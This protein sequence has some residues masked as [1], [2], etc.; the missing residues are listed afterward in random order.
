MR[1]KVLLLLLIIILSV[2]IVVR[3]RLLNI[4]I[5]R[6]EAEYAYGGQLIL[7][8]QI[9]YLEQYSLK[10]PGMFI[11]Y[12]IFLFV[13]G[14]SSIGIHIGLLIT[15][16]LSCFLIFNISK[17][18]FNNCSAVIVTS[19]FAILSLNENIQGFSANAE[20]F[21][22]LFTL[23]G[24]FYYFKYSE[25][26]LRKHLFLCGLMMAISF[27]MKQ[28]GFAFI[29]LGF[30]LVLHKQISRKEPIIKALTNIL[31]Y[32]FGVLLFIIFT[33]SLMYFLGT[34]EKF[35]FLTF[36][37][38]REYVSYINLEQGISN[39]VKNISNVIKGDY[40]LWIISVFGLLSLIWS[41][42]NRKQMFFIITLLLTSL[43]A[44][45]PG[46]Y[47]RPHYFILLLPI[48]AIMAGLFFNS[49]FNYKLESSK[50]IFSIIFPI[51]L[52]I[53]VISFFVFSHSA[54]LFKLS[55]TQVSKMIFGS[56]PFSESPEIAKYIVENSIEND[57]VAIIGAEPQ[58][59]FYCKRKSAT[60]Y[61]YVYPFLENNHYAEQMTHE[62]FREIE[63]S[64]PKLIVFSNHSGTWFGDE[65]RKK[66]IIEWFN[67]FVNNKYYKSGIIDILN[68]STTNYYWDN[69]INNYT[70]KGD[71]WLTVY[72]KLK[73]N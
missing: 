64:A 55:P 42:T 37:Y 41:K 1:F 30:V 9:P 23:A 2:V 7:N 26:L 25:T 31:L 38:A 50:K 19:F 36:T 17:K 63:K 47:F 4:P 73:N 3:I 56:N 34:F 40:L 65:T 49:F 53:T 39:F 60:G 59:L 8:G 18:L 58:M 32:I 27:T 43:L 33:L 72:K 22:V 11:I 48:V 70:L 10:Y 24:L 52:F 62:Y 6:D 29:I 5:D 69:D 35:W 14:Q 44:I 51:I 20:H 66:E 71:D 15:N 16:L 13:F 12:S 67:N 68:D 61:L 45:S 21:V 28:H 46:F 57:R 54:Y